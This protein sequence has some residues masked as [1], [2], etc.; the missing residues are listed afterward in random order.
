MD[1]LLATRL[2]FI[3]GLVNLLTLLALFFSCRCMGGLGLHSKM[4][5]FRVYK[6]LYGFH[7]YYW[8]ILGVSVAAHLGI[9]ISVLGIPFST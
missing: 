2:I 5:R 1:P 6:A 4:S 9:A 7:C 8:I 3:L